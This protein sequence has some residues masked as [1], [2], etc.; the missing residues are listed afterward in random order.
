M[1]HTVNDFYNKAVVDIKNKYWPTI[2]P[3]CDDAGYMAAK[4]CLE[5]FNNGCI[6]YRKLI[7]RLSKHCKDRTENIHAI[8]EK[9]IVSFGEY[10]YRPN[11][12]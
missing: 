1:I 9:H 11:K 12:K 4:H 7:G 2:H 5:L 10:E 3:L 8:I 6:N